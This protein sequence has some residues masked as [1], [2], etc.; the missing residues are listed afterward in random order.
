MCGL[1][2]AT[3]CWPCPPMVLRRLPAGRVPSPPHPNSG[4]P[5]NP[6]QNTTPSPHR[7]PMPQLRHPTPRH[8]TLRRLRSFHDPNRLRR[9]MPM[10][11]RT[12]NF[13]RTSP[14]PQRK[15]RHHPNS[16]TPQVHSHH[17]LKHP[18]ITTR[19]Q[20]KTGHPPGSSRNVIIW[21]SERITRTTKT[22]TCCLF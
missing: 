10:L 16:H 2:R 9:H 20:Q 4:H 12:R 11:R 7:V 22:A 5:D 3:P 15:S 8:P 18:G 13:R 21:K 19:L 6:C 17:N 1:S 14:R